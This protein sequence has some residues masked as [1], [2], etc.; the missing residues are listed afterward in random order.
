MRPKVRQFKL[1]T[2]FRKK[3]AEYRVLCNTFQGKS[4]NLDVSK[5]FTKENIQPI[6]FKD[7][8]DVY[9]SL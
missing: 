7:A 3:E 6:N 2:D 4:L 5:C 8:S 9:I 1:N